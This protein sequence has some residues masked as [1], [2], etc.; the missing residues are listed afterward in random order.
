[1]PLVKFEPGI[2]QDTRGA[3]KPWLATF[4]KRGKTY[5]SS[6]EEARQVR[7]DYAEKMNHGKPRPVGYLCVHSMMNKVVKKVLKNARRRG[8]M[9]NLD[10]D[11][12]IARNKKNRE[13]QMAN[14]DKMRAAIDDWCR[15]NAQHRRECEN[16]RNAERRKTDPAFVVKRRVRSRICGFRKGKGAGKADTTFNQVCLTPDQLTKHLLSQ[17]RNGEDVIAMRIDHIFP[18]AAY[19]V[20]DMNQQLQMNHY[21][22]MQP[23]TE[24]ENSK[25][26]DMLPTRDMAAKVEKWAWP[27]GITEDM[28][29]DIYDGWST[30]LRM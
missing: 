8:R 10:D 29:P 6:L 7:L 25:K 30:S 27:P 11:R 19:D 4:G 22:N 21:T 26:S 15:R 17:L 14:R 3:T 23:L 28:L 24:S 5:C 2:Y 9:R 20:C 12:R 18:M 1:M 16:A 13:W